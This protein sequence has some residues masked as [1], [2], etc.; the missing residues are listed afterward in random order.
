MSARMAITVDEQLRLAALK[1]AVD[2][3]SPG[4]HQNDVTSRAREYYDF[5]TD[6]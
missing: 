1:A 3:T 6:S 2:T 5:L 4:A